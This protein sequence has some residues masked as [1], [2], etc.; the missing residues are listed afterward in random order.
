M[1]LKAFLVAQI[2]EVVAGKARDQEVSGIKVREGGGDGV[3]TA[4][5]RGREARYSRPV[6]Q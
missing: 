4:G 3:N 6:S 2:T 1:G 5:G